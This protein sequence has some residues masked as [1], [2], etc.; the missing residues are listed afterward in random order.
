MCA[1]A[2]PCRHSQFYRGPCDPKCSW[3]KETV[4]GPCI[5]ARREWLHASETSAW[6][7]GLSQ[8]LPRKVR[9]KL[10]ADLLAHIAHKSGAISEQAGTGTWRIGPY[11]VRSTAAYIAIERRIGR[12]CVDEAILE[13]WQLLLSD[14]LWLASA[15]DKISRI[16]IHIPFAPFKAQAVAE[17]LEALDE[18]TDHAEALLEVFEQY[19][20]LAQTMSLWWGS[21]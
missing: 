1:M 13:T 16:I 21:V 19:P 7:K 14:R 2:R 20:D 12:Y 3:A 11:A 17:I 18:A 6:C 4:M 15:R 10:T 8:R 5:D 9:Q